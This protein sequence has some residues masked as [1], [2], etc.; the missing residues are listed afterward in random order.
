VLSGGIS[1][2]LA[3]RGI[4]AT[5]VGAGAGEEEEEEEEEEGEDEGEL[6]AAQAES[7][8]EMI[9]AAA[10]QCRLCEKRRTMII[11]EALSKDHREFERLLGELVTA[12][13]ANDDGWK[14]IL[15]EL[16]RGVLA[17]AHAEEAVFYNALREEDAGKG[18]VMHSYA[19]HAKAEAIMRTLGAAKLIDANWTSLVE[20]LREDL[21][22]HIQEEESKVFDAA[23]KCFSDDEANQIGAA[24][25]HMKVETAKTGDSMVA[26]TIELIANLLPPRLTNRFRKNV[27]RPHAA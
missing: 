21:T 9:M 23:R 3:S 17:H 13:K 8:A 1:L 4:G 16:R 2:A 24:F 12:S 6:L 11:Y 10:L 27:G 19:E 5:G 14:R 20:K 25:E 22:H 7:D 18:L 15:D 26:S